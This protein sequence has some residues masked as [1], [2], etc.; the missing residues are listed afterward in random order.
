MWDILGAL[1]HL[2]EV[3]FVETGP[4]DDAAGH[5]ESGVSGSGFRV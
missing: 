2:G 3:D 1:I 5:E 4:S